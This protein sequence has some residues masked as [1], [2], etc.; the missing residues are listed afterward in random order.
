M[1]KTVIA[2]NIKKYRKLRGITQ[3][4]LAKSAQL[5]PAGIGHIESGDI[6]NP[7]IDTAKKISDALA[8]T[9]DQLIAEN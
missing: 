2:Q 7:T 5:S 1:G 8:I 6:K 9:I 4:Q 3:I